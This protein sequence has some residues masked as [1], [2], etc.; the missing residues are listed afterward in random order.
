MCGLC[1]L[2]GNVEHWSSTSSRA[3]AGG[4][5]LG[6]ANPLRERAL[7]VQAVNRVAAAV[8]VQVEDWAG[9]SWIVRNAFG[10]TDIVDSLPKIWRSAEAL[11][12]KQID[13]LSPAIIQRLENL[14]RTM[15]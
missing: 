7:Q 5:R 3:V 1:G 9:T 6:D 8:G 4:V 2:W 14:N 12:G 10:A 13:P 15:R 11:S